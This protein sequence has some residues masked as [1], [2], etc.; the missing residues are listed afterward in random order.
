MEKSFIDITIKKYLEEKFSF[1]LS[2]LDQDST[3]FTINTLSKS[4]YIK[5]IAF[6]KYVIINTSESIHL[7]VKSALSGKSRDEIF[8]FPFVY[9]QTIHFIP[10]IKKI[11]DYHL[12]M[13]IHMNY[14]KGT[15]SIN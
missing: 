7:K 10:D 11:K 12:L 4:P 5:I 6:N 14:Y 9:G 3:I 13:A 15:T 1:N 2:E 8:E